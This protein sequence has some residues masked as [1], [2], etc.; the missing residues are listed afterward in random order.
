MPASARPQ[1]RKRTTGTPRPRTFDLSRQVSWL[2]GHCLRKAFPGLRPVALHDVGSPLTVAGWQRRHWPDPRS[3]R[4]GFPLGSGA[5]QSRRPRPADYGRAPTSRQDKYKDMFISLY[6][7]KSP[8]LTFKHEGDPVPAH[9]RDA[10][11]CLWPQARAAC[12]AFQNEGGNRSACGR[13]AAAAAARD[14]VT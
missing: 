13:A 11:T 14:E 8:L 4:T 9:F 5:K 3:V 10:H 12:C 6:L 2:A 1:D 7:L